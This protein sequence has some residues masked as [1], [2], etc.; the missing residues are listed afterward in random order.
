MTDRFLYAMVLKWN[1]WM[2]GVYNAMSERGKG[3]EFTMSVYL[4]CSLFLYLLFLDTVIVF[5]FSII[6]SRVGRL[7]IRAVGA[8]LTWFSGYDILSLTSKSTVSS[9][10][11]VKKSICSSSRPDL[12]NKSDIVL[13]KS[14]GLETYFSCLWLEHPF[15]ETNDPWSTIDVVSSDVRVKFL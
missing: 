7:N 3:P 5:C 14:A 11:R 13:S 1:Y 10:Y 6:S 4:F 8:G 9:K 12:M 15:I 2:T